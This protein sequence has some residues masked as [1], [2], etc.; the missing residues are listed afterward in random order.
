MAPRSMPV[1]ASEFNAE[2]GSTTRNVEAFRFFAE[3][4]D[5]R[6]QIPAGAPVVA[7][8]H[9]RALERFAWRRRRDLVPRAACDEARSGNK[10]EAS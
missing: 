7:V 3:S 1:Q 2:A 8:R 9:G 5:A 10:Q 4:S 6:R